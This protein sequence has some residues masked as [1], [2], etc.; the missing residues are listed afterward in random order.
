MLWLDMCY[1]AGMSNI[2]VTQGG[3]MQARRGAFPKYILLTMGLVILV[4]G[5]LLPTWVGWAAPGTNRFQANGFSGTCSGGNLSSL[6]SSFAWNVADG[7]ERWGGEGST[8]PPTINFILSG[9][10]SGNLSVTFSPGT[11]IYYLRNYIYK[12]GTTKVVASLHVVWSCL[13]G[14]GPAQVVAAVRAQGSG[15]KAGPPA[16]NLFDGRINDFQDRDV[17]AEVAIYLGS[18]KVYAI[19]PSNGMGTLAVDISSEHIESVGVPTEANVLLGEGMNA[20]TGFPIAVYR[21]TTGE[22]QLNTAYHDGKPY[23][24]VWDNLLDNK[25][26]LAW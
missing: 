1:N 26:H 6:S 15:S 24:F 17:G 8:S 3:T 14:D 22:F 5:A 13:S 23:V 25:Y 18:I 11:P 20:A 16:M 10:D 4:L 19:D 2:V 9:P 7:Y 21:L 12:S